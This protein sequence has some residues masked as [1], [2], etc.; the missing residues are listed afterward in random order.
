MADLVGSVIVWLRPQL[1]PAAVV[2]KR[3]RGQT[4][5]CLVVRRVGGPFE[6]PVVDNATV[7]LE[8]YGLT[9]AQAWDLITDARALVWSLR[10]QVVNG[11]A[12]YRL[13][14]FAGPAFLPDPDTEGT[15]RYTLTVSIRHREHLATA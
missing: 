7:T 5:P 10:G 13:D 8:A 4:D 11:I 9:V 15:P 1:A 14:E 6:W 3:D 2:H 12:V